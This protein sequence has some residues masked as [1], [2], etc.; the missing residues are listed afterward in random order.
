MPD[1][2]QL[3]LVVG[4]FFIASL[5]ALAVAV[6]SLTSESG[7]FASQYRIYGKFENVQGLLPGAPVWMAGKEVGHVEAVEFTEFGSDQPIVVSMRINHSIQNRVRTDSVATIGTIGVLGDSYIEIRPGSFEGSVLID[8]EEIEALSPTNLYAVLAQGTE[9]LG[10][11][12]ELARSLNLVV[13]D[14]REEGVIAKGASA[15]SA[16]S[17]II[18]EIETG[19]G[20]LHS[21]IYDN[22]GGGGVSSIEASLASLE[23]ILGEVQTGDGILNSLIYGDGQDSQQAGIDEAI[24][25]LADIFEEIKNGEGLLHSMIYDA[26]SS[27]I[28]DDAV[29]ALTRVNL[30]LEKIENGDGTLGLLISD[31]ALY[32]D[33]TLLLGGAKRSALL[34][35]LVRMAVDP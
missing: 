18:L 32:E 24:A 33:M 21:V 16:M 9:A 34:R 35:T 30:I 26:E 15:V 2:R 27:R 5:V 1:S 7:L 6:L 17:N 10:N 19:N 29:A 28:S 20:M 12:S 22:S 14:V 25:A 3:S 4:A 13:T 11:V 8:G 31:P 23:D